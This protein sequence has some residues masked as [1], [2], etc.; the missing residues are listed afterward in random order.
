MKARLQTSLGQHLVMTPQL[1]QAIRLLQMSTLELQ[2][3]VAEAIETNPLLEWTEDAPYDSPVPTDGKAGDGAADGPGNDES[4]R[5]GADDD[6]MPEAGS[7]EG[8]LGGGS[9]GG[10]GG[11]EDREDAAE[12]MAEPE[13]L[14]DH[15]LWQLHLSPLSPRD[16]RIG[17]AL[18]DALDEDGYL[19][20]PLATIAETLLPEVHAGEEEILTVLHQLQRFDPVGIGA[21]SLGECL[22]LQLEVLPEDPPGREL[23]LRIVDGPLE[24]LPRSGIAGIA[25]ELRAPQDAV[26]QAVQLVRSL[27]PRP[28]KQVGEVD[29]DNYV[30][31]DCVVWRQRGVWKVALSQ[32]A[33]PRVSIHRG[34]EQ[35]IRRCGESDAGYLRTQLQEARWLLKSLEARGE[36]LLKVMRCLLRVQSGFLE[37]GEQALRPLTLREIAGEIGL[38]ESTVSRA[39][40]RK[41]VRTPRGTL[42]LKAFFASGIDTGGGGE[43]SSTAIQAMIRRLI[44]DE[45]PRK[46]LSDAKLADLLK[47]SGI[48]VARRTVAK[49]REAM[50]IS[51]SHE[52]VR[53]G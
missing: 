1:R 34:Y 16:R 14:A 38:H 24:R 11:D 47:E 43:A 31:P 50:N 9:G 13:N 44:D 48:P 32:Q 30:I 52:R 28:G 6:W 37:F 40:A 53:I 25:Q 7:W 49:Y 22:R 39:I 33:M 41:Y 26:E 8:G 36:T 12:R 45:N 19:R 18:V 35:M 29:P 51:A 21:R 42:P 2:A 5:D 23:A 4:P 15:L 20:E 46:P 27:D 10:G 3:E 17:A